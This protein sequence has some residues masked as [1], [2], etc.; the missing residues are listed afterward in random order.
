[1]R[2]TPNITAY[3]SLYNLQQSRSILD[4]LQEKVAS[5]KNYNRPSDDPVMARQLIGFADQ[6]R[7]GEQHASNMTKATIWLKV[8]NAALGGMA[9]TMAEIKKLVSTLT[10][11]TDMV[12]VRQNA[13]AQ[14]ETYKKQLVD[15]GNTQLNGVYVMAGTGD[16]LT[17]PFSGSV[18]TGDD[19]NI[20]VEIGS[21]ITQTMNITGGRVLKGSN[22]APQQY[23]SVDILTE[24]DNL[25]AAVNANDAAAITAGAQKM[26]EGALQINA[27]IA[28]VGGRLTRLE[29]M[30]K[31]NL[32]TK[33]VIQGV[34][35]DIQN[36]D[37]TKLAV[38]MQQQQLAYQATLSS[39]AKI[40][41]ISLLDY[42]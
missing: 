37:Y 2:I 8:T 21:S 26:E 4:Q 9:S 3:N 20:D 19:N 27:A 39:T 6:L 29:N 22:T 16:N 11:G 18:Y 25:I 34:V 17:A 32:T 24:L 41:Q 42:L 15:Y 31:F 23:G 5:G 12:E 38:E 7:A 40:S 14:L 28:D 30:Q 33:N 13:A 10:N 36:A 35:A 1:M